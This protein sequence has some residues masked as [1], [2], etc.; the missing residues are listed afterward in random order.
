MKKKIVII[1]PIIAVN[2]DINNELIINFKIL[3]FSTYSKCFKEKTGLSL[4]LSI[5][6]K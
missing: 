4:G 5:K 6:A 1:V 3:L 2:I